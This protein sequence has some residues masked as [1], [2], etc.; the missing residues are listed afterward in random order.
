MYDHDEPSVPGVKEK[1]GATNSSF[2]MRLQFLEFCRLEIGGKWYRLS[3]ALPW[4]LHVKLQD[5]GDG[6]MRNAGSL[7][8]P[9]N[10]GW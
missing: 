5:P 3:D 2:E 7:S 10:E 9:T 6:H 1:A 8:D 4:R